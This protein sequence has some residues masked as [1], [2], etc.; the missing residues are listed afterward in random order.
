MELNGQNKNRFSKLDD[1]SRS[2]I[3]ELYI[4][5]SIKERFLAA[6]IAIHA[7][8]NVEKQVT[9]T[10][11][12]FLEALKQKKQHYEKIREEL[13]SFMILKGHP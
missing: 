7:L 12:D 2:L 8:D 5:D 11:N 9:L 10:M 1:H 6:D 3:Y 13:K 4:S